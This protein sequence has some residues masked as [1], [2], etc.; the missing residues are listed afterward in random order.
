VVTAELPEP[1][2][3]RLAPWVFE[4][5]RVEDAVPVRAIPDRAYPDQAALSTAIAAAPVAD[6]PVCLEPL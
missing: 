5:D 2:V 1:F 3:L 6:Q 4:P